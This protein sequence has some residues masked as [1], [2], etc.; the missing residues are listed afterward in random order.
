MLVVAASCF[1]VRMAK[2]S[3]RQ[4]QALVLNFVKC[5]AENYSPCPLG[6][7]Q[8]KQNLSAEWMESFH[9]YAQWQCVY[10]DS[11]R[12]NSILMRPLDNVSPAFLFDGQLVMRYAMLQRNIKKEVVEPRDKKLYECLLSI[13][14]QH[15]VRAVSAACSM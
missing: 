11:M 14:L 9:C 3:I 4:I 10:K 2:P 6:Y 1:W 5:S 8:T 15:T 7:S 13:L 12:L